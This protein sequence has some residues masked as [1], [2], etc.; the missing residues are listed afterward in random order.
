MTDDKLPDGLLRKLDEAAMADLATHVLTDNGIPDNEW[1]R[2]AF[3]YGFD[4]GHAQGFEDATRINDHL[5]A[6]LLPVSPAPF[7]AV[8][9]LK[10]CTH[11]PPHTIV[12][13]CPDY[14]KAEG[15]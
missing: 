10:R 4:A 8:N 6:K 12:C 7:N 14:L 2:S 15:V 11:G 1:T 13:D 3:Y 9:A 5:L